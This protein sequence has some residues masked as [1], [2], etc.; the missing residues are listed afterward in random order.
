[1]NPAEPLNPHDLPAEL[2]ARR[3]LANELTGLAR[4]AQSRG[5]LITAMLHASDALMLFPNERPFLDLVDEVALASPDPLSLVPVAS[6]AVHVATAAAR[7]RILMMRK[8]MPAAIELL[9]EVVQVAP[10][11]AYLPW[12]QRWLAQPGVAA[13]FQFDQLG[14]TVVRAALLLGSRVSVPPDAGDPRL[15]NVA[16][17]AEI[18]ATLR[19]QFPDESVLYFGEVLLRRRLGDPSATLA[20][21]V[22]GVQ[23]FPQDARMQISML[24]ALRDAKRPDEAFAHARKALELDPSDGAPLYDAGWAF[25][26]AGRPQD[27]LRVFEELLARF[28]DY[29]NG[30][31]AF[32]AVRFRATGAHEDRV[33]LV[34]LRE[35]EWWNDEAVRLANEVD[36]VRVYFN[37]LPGPSDAS[38]AAGREI[39]REVAHVVHC[40]GV[41]GEL[42]LGV[43][44]QY[45]ESPSVPLAFD[46]ALRALG[47]RGR[48]DVNV[49]E[50]QMP[51]PRA[52]KAPLPFRIWTY[53]G[54]TPK[55]VYPAADPRVH[56]AIA[57][58]AGSLFRVETWDPAA[59][60]L[61]QQMGPDWLHALL[62]ALT[63]PP[64]PP[65]ADFDPF[66]WTYRCQ[67]ATALVLSYL[68][69]S[70][71]EGPGRTAIYALLYGPTDW[72]T[73]AAIIALGFRAL[74]EPALRPEV[75][76]VFQWLR[77]Q[78]PA[79]G[80][81]SFESV[82]ANVWLGLGGHSPQNEAELNEW[83]EQIEE[84]LPTKNV[85]KPPTR[86]YGG[87]TLEQYAE[88]SAER[89]RIMGNVS[90]QGA[91][92]AAKNFLGEPP[93]ALAA[94]CQ[95][96][97]VPLRGSDGHVRPYIQEWQ[98]AINA[99]PDLGR[100][101]AELQRAQQMQKLGVSG[102]E[103]AALDQI[104]AG[105]MDMHL[106]MAQQQQAQRAVA[107]GNA[108]DPDPVVF[109]GQKVQKLSDYVRIMKRMQ[110]GDFMGAIGE[111]GL[112][113]MSYSSVAT[114]WGAKF[115]AD[116]TLNEKF[117]RMMQS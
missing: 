13:R 72:T 86:R 58:I 35:R 74:T 63:D 110:G 21:A 68:G 39:S 51:D 116:P 70:W 73:D 83:I 24:N 20:V 61:A 54:T 57:G 16:A 109:P 95:H 90:V 117:S 81:T 64:L 34:T 89:D 59:R 38:A 40:C 93:P 42:S 11:L 105:E 43:E 14:P 2:E 37:Y 4:Q 33:A 3:A 91:F 87:L 27:G 47:A 25:V 18:F 114:A 53:E 113:M 115:A 49:A 69:S 62:A 98:E 30:R 97:N 36:P 101:F 75:E 92:A 65:N 55:R 44:S 41:G 94:L 85:V 78:V 100:H 103:V 12:V 71:Q 108:G 48:L 26:D 99:N 56:G 45:L 22:A 112:D 10:D 50:V 76:S 102:E 88:F 104:R 7:A 28:P 111:Y 60:G 66:T 1:M 106:R 31:A 79:K 19:A 15:P 8:D 17:S 67:V 84:E 46:L 107:E 32:H 82:L 29:P 23:R 96:F 6:G 9:S 52:D 77:G 5:E 80:Y